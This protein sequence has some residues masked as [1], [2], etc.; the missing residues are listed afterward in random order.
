MVLDSGTKVG[1]YPAG[2]TDHAFDVLARTLFDASIKLAR[3]TYRKP[4]ILSRG[5]PIGGLFDITTEADFVLV[6]RDACVLSPFP[7]QVNCT[8]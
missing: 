6:D 2:L 4:R 7:W 8:S 3:G 5:S 1:K